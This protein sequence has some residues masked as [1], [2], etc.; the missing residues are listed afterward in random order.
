MIAGN[1]LKR[2]ALLIGYS[3]W[4]LP[5]KYNL[6]GVSYD[7]KNYRSFLM[8]NEGGAW[9]YDEITTIEDKE[10]S[11]I[12]VKLNLIKAQHNEMVFVVYSGHGDYDDIENGCRRLQISKNDDILENE[13][14]N[15]GKR[16]ILILDSCSGKRSN[17]IDEAL[18]QKNIMVLESAEANIRKQYRKRYEELFMKCPERNLRFYAAEV[19]K[20]AHDTDFGG[21]YS[22]C[23]LDTLRKSFDEMDIITAHKNAAKIVITKTQFDKNPQIPDS[24]IIKDGHTLPGK[25]NA[26]RRFV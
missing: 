13:L 17:E 23:L 18:E 15:L 26:S 14:I 21:L 4:D 7:L 10:L 25:V 24:D 9:N 1:C 6:D 11:T 22:R 16:E 2:R 3:G 12:R 19:G 5:E 20:S 8:S